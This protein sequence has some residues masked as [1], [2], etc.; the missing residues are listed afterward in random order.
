VPTLLES[1]FG[2]LDHQYVALQRLRRKFS[3]VASCDYGQKGK[4]HD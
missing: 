1:G 4:S 2:H 3:V